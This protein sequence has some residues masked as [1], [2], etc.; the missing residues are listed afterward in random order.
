M[1]LHVVLCCMTGVLV[2]SCPF[3]KRQASCLGVIV[4][5]ARIWN[6]QSYLKT[7]LSC[8][9]KGTALPVNSSQRA[10]LPL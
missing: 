8:L 5:F 4:K 1:L 7:G 6:P 10:R 2:G 9:L 3:V